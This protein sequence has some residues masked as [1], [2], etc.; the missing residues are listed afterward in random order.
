MK[1]VRQHLSLPWFALQ[2]NIDELS[3]IL[4]EKVSDLLVPK[5]VQPKIV[6]GFRLFRFRFE[7]S[8]PSINSKVASGL[9]SLTASLVNKKAF[10]H[11]VRSFLAILRTQRNRV[12]VPLNIQRKTIVSIVQ[13]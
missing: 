5:G 9:H 4:R 7:R 2:S 10:V 13:I 11:D 8:H 1:R 12:I 6:E 3:Q